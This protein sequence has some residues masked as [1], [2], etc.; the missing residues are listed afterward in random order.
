MSND[1]PKATLWMPWF[2]KD[3][4][5]AASTLDHIEHSALCYLKMLLWENGGT[6][7]DDD[8]WIAKHVRLPVQKWK[9]LRIAVLD[10]CIVENGVIAMP[11][12]AAEFIKAQSNIEQKRRAGIASASARKRATHVERPLD[13][14]DRSVATSGA[15]RAGSGGGGGPNHG[16][17]SVIES[18]ADD[19]GENPFAVV[20]GGK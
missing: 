18:L 5:A 1:T 7:P 20:Q 10:G 3:H 17:S 14:R 2:I 8:K 9:A 15:P 13:E 16:M 6:I 12:I 11:E 4:K 19:V